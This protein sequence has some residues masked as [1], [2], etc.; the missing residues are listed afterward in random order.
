MLNYDVNKEP[1]FSPVMILREHFKMARF[2]KSDINDPLFK[3]EN[4]M[5]DATIALIGLFDMDE[6]NKYVM[7]SNN[8]TESP[9]VMAGVKQKNV[10]RG[11]TFA[12]TQIE[13]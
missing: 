2:F 12:I 1:W 7:Q 13:V 10:G 6:T 11:N 4:E 9:D 3:R 8:Q 5:F